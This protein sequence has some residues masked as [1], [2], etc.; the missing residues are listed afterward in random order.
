MQSQLVSFSPHRYI[1]QKLEF[2]KKVFK[3]KKRSLNLTY[4]LKPNSVDFIGFIKF[5]AF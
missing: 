2:K 3:P 1:Q 5:W 4:F